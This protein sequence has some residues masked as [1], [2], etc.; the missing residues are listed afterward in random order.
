MP[1]DFKAI[2][3]VWVAT[4]LGRPER[5]DNEETI[6]KSISIGGCLLVMYDDSQED[7]IIGTSWMTFDARRIHLHHFGILPQ[8]QGK[9]LSR[10]LLKESLQFVK[11]KGRQVKIEVDRKNSIALDLYKKAGFRY[12]GDYDVYIIRN[13]EEIRL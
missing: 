7:R 6:I 2:M 13:L 4:G 5:G 3:D 12:L 10:L 8:Y 11:E 9:G 1:G